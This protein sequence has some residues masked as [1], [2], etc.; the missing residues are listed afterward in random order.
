MF[1]INHRLSDT[2]ASLFFI[3]V[4]ISSLIACSVPSILKWNSFPDGTYPNSTPIYSA[5]TSREYYVSLITTVGISIPIL[6]DF[7]SRI[8]LS[9]KF[10]KFEN[11]TQN[12][13]L[14][15]SAIIS[16]TALDLFCLLYVVPNVDLTA[17]N[18][19]VKVKIIMTSSSAFYSI[20][21]YG[22]DQW[23][24]H[25]ILT[26]LF[27]VCSG[28]VLSIYRVHLI[29]FLYQL[30]MISTSILDSCTFL[31]FICMTMK[32]F[33]ILYKDYKTKTITK[34]QYL[35]TVYTVSYLFLLCVYFSVQYSHPQLSEWYYASNINLIAFFFVFCAYYVLI[36]ILEGKALQRD[37]LLTQVCEV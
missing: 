7:F 30:I 20:Y 19:V 33:S 4:T 6:I 27:C 31:L 11:S 25:G 17:L 22:K 12:V 32:W 24:S 23:S 1:Q 10:P 34:D 8:V 14:V 3:I 16:L 29:G 2:N 35:C 36:L 26:C 21:K 37:V 9:S 13:Y 15:A 5:V 18:Y 28:R